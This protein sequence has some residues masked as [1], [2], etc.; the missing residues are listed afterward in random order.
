MKWNTKH[1]PAATLQ[2]TDKDLE[3]VATDLDHH[4][5]TKLPDGRLSG[6][7]AG[8]EPDIR[9]QAVLMALQW[10]IAQCPTPVAEW[11]PQKSISHAL[12]YAKLRQLEQIRRRS[13][14]YY[15]NRKDERVT[16]HPLSLNEHDYPEHGLLQMLDEV[17]VTCMNRGS[18]SKS[19][20]VIARMVYI[21]GRSIK[22]V[23]SHLGRHTSAIYQQLW[24]VQKAV[25][26]VTKT[27][28]STFVS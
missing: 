6:T 16:Q 8:Y 7:L 3:L 26:E 13:E 14:C 5:K 20:A 11:I 10:W 21:E 17:L 19:N 9:Q 15:D 24:R 25:K 27:T 4:A 23:A 2:I 28:D 12:R 18:I 22:E 1:T